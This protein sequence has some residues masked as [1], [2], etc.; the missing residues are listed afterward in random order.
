MPS[1]N[2]QAPIDGGDDA[3]LEGSPFKKW[4]GPRNQ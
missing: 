2:E 4:L 1:N 3:L